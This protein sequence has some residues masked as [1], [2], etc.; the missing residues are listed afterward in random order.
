MSVLVI[1]DFLFKPEGVD[2]FME[3]VKERLPFARTYEGCQEIDLFRDEDDPNHFVLVER[4][5]SRPHYDKYRAW[6]M[7]QPGTEQLV[8]ALQRD[9][10]TMYLEKTEA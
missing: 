8:Q 5:E 10:T 7:A 4:W 2:P 6:A 1:V 3:T 9:M